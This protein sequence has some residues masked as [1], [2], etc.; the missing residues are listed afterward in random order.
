[1]AEGLMPPFVDPEGT[2]GSDA[3]ALAAFINSLDTCYSPRF[4]VEGPVLVADRV[5]AAAL[6]VAARTILVRT[7]PPDDLLEARL[8]LEQALTAAGYEKHDEETLWATPVALQIL[9]LRAS[10]WDLWGQD[11][12]VAFDDLRQAAMGDDDAPIFASGPSD[13]WL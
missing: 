12:E 2:P 11:L 3:Q 6:R 4:H 5:T 8:E 10:S 7:D 1:M 13:G 9:G